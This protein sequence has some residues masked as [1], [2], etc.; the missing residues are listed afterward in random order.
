MRKRSFYP[1]LAAQNMK[2]NRQFYIPYLLATI[3]TTAAFYILAAIV[4]D[5]GAGRLGEGTTNGQ[6]YVSAFMTLGMFVVGLFSCIFLLYTNSFL[7]K[8]RKKEFGLYNVLGMGKGNIGTIMVFETIYTM[9]IGI[10]GG[11]GVGIL[12]HKLVTLLLHKMMRFEVHFGFMISAK[13]I[14]L[15]VGVFSAF[16]IMTL[17]SNLI[18]IRRSKTVE[19]L[20]GGN[21]GEREPKTRWLLTIIGILSLGTGYWLA[22]TVKDGME[23]IAFYF[24]AVFAVIIGTYCLFTAVSISVLKALRKNKRIYYKTNNFIGISGM[25]YR[26]KRNAVGLANICILATMVMVMV[27]GTLSMYLG[28]EESI[29][30][31][32]PKNTVATTSFKLNDEERFKPES[33]MDT[34]RAAINEYGYEIKSEDYVTYYT[35]AAALEPDGG[36]TCPVRT[37]SENG[38]YIYVNMSTAADYARTSGTQPVNLE[39]DEVLIFGDWGRT[40]G[41]IEVNLDGNPVSFNIAGVL[42]GEPNYG[43]SQRITTEKYYLIFSDE[44]VS[45]EM[46]L[47]SG[48]GSYLRCESRFDLDCTEAEQLEFQ[49]KFW[50]ENRSYEGTGS[51]E[52]LSLSV[53]AVEETEMY[54]LAGGFLFLGIFLGIVFL[55]ATALIIY[56]KQIS[57]GYEDQRRFEIMSQVGL[58]QREIKR[59]VRS[60]VLMVFFLPIVVAAI[61]IAF[62]FNMVINLLSLFALTNVKLTAICTLAT[63]LAFS[64]VYAVMY[65][66]TAKAYYKIVKN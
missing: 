5:P 54:G 21:V 10:A 64:A 53:R 58:S 56:Y 6:A 19:L 57:E 60:Q 26:M 13:A 63:L 47:K 61:H 2:N 4:N 66:L 16:L 51:W 20:S 38:Q 9:L 43:H 41:S 22:I 29:E 48:G 36:L 40:E 3:G 23:A 65:V 24:V 39:A 44:S 8:R 45:D 31:T 42:D 30:K 1:K 18:S 35:F 33:M 37:A 34:L 27:S 50:Q 49:E 52:M 59:S 12:L 46:V 62:D 11:I 7:I 32:F 55:M 14:L 25:I 15:T 28:V 17:I